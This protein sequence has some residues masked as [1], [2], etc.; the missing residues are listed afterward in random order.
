M[1]EDPEEVQFINGVRG[2][3]IQKVGGILQFIGNWGHNTGSPIQ[4]IK[5]GAQIAEREEARLFAGQ[6]RRCKAPACAVHL[7]I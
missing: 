6:A 1:Q 4:L 5:C 2:V 3:G 7:T